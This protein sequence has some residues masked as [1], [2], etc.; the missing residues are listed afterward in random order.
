[1]YKYMQYYGVSRQR[2][3]RWLCTQ[4]TLLEV[5]RHPGSLGRGLPSS[6]CRSPVNWIPH[7]TPQAMNGPIF[8]LG[9]ARLATA[10]GQIDRLQY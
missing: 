5:V 4:D 1:M 8:P 3:G 6:T 7:I 2:L 9:S 10:V